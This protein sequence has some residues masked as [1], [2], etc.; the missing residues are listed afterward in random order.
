MFFRWQRN[1]VLEF[2]WGL[3]I[4][5]CLLNSPYFFADEKP[6]LLPLSKQIEVRESWLHKRHDILLKIMQKHNIDMWIV[7][8][9]EFHDDPLTQ[10]IAPPRPYT[11]RR[12]I[13]V[14]AVSDSSILKKHA[15]TGYAE[16]NLRR[17]FESPEEPQPAKAILPELYKKY[18]PQQIALNTGGQRGV[19][20]SLTHDSYLFLSEV[21]GPEASEKFVSASALLEEYL[22]TRIPEEFEHYKTAVHLTE[23]LVKQ[24]FSSKVITPGKTTIGDLR[25]WLYD[26]MCEHS[27]DTWFQPDF[28]LQRRGMPKPT[29]RG[30]LAVAKEDWIIQRGDLL[31]VDFGITYMGFDTDWQKMAYVLLEGETDAPAGLKQAMENTNILQDALMKRHSRPGITV[32][33]VYTNTM[34]EMKERNIQA[35]IYSHPLGP[36]GHG[37]GA[38]ID[39]R[40]ARRGDTQ[41]QS[42]KLRKGSYIAIELNTKTAIPEWDGQEVFIMMED[43]A[44][45]TDEGWVFFRPR[46]EKFYLIN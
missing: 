30:F 7:V 46:Q 28:R 18:Q 9:E 33:E 44:Y 22:D 10:Y 37:L 42:K 17:F 21:L 26:A 11:G 12:D 40:S 1:P 43:D 16:D 2:R 13:F 34:Q 45:L 27:V 35:Q 5:I 14:F 19:T 4:C 29:S 41:R 23:W 39:F 32:A 20:R 3:F 25:R 36:Q 31:H 24:V 15:I 8:N 38:S 6:Q